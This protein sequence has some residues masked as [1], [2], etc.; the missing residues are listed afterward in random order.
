MIQNINQSYF[1]EKSLIIKGFFILEMGIGQSRVAL[2]MCMRLLVM[3]LVVLPMEESN[4]PQFVVL[5]LSL[6]VN[7]V[8]LTGIIIKIRSDVRKINGEKFK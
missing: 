1:P 6:I 3:G 7:V 2:T 5:I 4:S 8:T